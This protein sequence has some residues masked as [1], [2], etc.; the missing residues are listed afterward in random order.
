MYSYGFL[1]A[2]AANRIRLEFAEAE[3]FRLAHHA[4]A[5][6]RAVRTKRGEAGSKNLSLR[7]PRR[8]AT[9]IACDAPRIRL[10]RT[11]S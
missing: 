6:S 11:T 9:R 8:S 1:E 5:G 2:L 3:E 10:Q 4:R 7:I